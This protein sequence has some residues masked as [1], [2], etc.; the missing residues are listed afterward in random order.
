MSQGM[1]WLEQCADGGSGRDPVVRFSAEP[2]DSMR[3]TQIACSVI[4]PMRYVLSEVPHE[5][6]QSDIAPETV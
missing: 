6:G 5:S 2:S 4:G 3:G 1:D